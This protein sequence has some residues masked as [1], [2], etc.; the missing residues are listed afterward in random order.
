MGSSAL[1]AESETIS[2]KIIFDATEAVLAGRDYGAKNGVLPQLAFLE[3]VSQGREG[4]IDPKKPDKTKEEIQ[5]I[6]PDELLLVLGSA[7]IFPVVLTNLTITEQK[8]LPNLVPLRA[9]VELKLTV[10]EP[11]ESRYSAL[12]DTAFAQLTQRRSAAAQEA[13]SASIVDR[14]LGRTESEYESE[15]DSEWCDVSSDPSSRHSDSATYRV[16]A[17]VEL[18]VP[19]MRTR[20]PAVRRHIASQSDRL[21]ILAA[22]YLGDPHL[23]WRIADTNPSIPPERLVEPG[24]AIDIPGPAS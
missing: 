3:I 16:S 1:L 13:S 12:V 19:R 10:L 6:R 11:I 22:A 21:D 7:R 4:N 24:G 15:S 20:P 9:E 14:D 8:F 5:P 18:L 17:E 23:Y 2:F